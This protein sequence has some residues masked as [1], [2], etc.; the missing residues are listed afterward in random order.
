MKAENLEILGKLEK[1]KVKRED[2]DITGLERLDEQTKD[3][4]VALKC[5]GQFGLLYKQPNLEEYCIR[6]V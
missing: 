3:I 4:K 2:R 1:R 5:G 6:E